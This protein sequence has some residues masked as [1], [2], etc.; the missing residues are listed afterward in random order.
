VLEVA[1]PMSLLQITPALG[2]VFGIEMDYNDDDDGGTRD[3]KLKTY[4]KSDDTWQNPSM[5]VPARLVDAP[6]VA[7]RE[8]IRKAPAAFR[9]VQNYPNPFNPATTIVYTLDRPGR[10]NLTVTDVLGREIA[11]LVE[12]RQMAGK[13]E[14]RFDGTDLAGGMYLVTLR[15]A[16]RH[17]AGKMLL[18]K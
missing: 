7:V 3:T 6:A 4:S 2:S 11:V 8:R 14:V 10:V 5:M 9:M 16:D 17:A 18:L 13:H 15:T 12:G 1:F